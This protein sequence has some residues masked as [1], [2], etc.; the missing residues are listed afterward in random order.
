MA[1]ELGINEHIG[2]AI[3]CIGRSRFDRLVLSAR[4]LPS[5]SGNP[6][7]SSGVASL[8]V[9]SVFTS[10]FSKIASRIDFV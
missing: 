2:T 4:D 1:S 6:W 7:S 8:F 10:F 5:C 3:C 9:R